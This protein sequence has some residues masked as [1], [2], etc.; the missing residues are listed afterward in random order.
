MLVAEFSTEVQ[1]NGKEGLRLH[2]N[3][4]S[5]M[6]HV[7]SVQRMV[8]TRLLSTDGRVAQELRAQGT[9]QMLD[10]ARLIAG[11]YILEVLR[12]DGHRLRSTFVKN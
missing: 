10:V 5:D 9:R 8:G 7:T 2:P 4:A 12:E 11:I 1:E 6:L 3:P